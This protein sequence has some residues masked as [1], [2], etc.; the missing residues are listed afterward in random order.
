MFSPQFVVAAQPLAQAAWFC[1][2]VTHVPNLK[3]AGV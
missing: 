2:I 3:K 1:Q